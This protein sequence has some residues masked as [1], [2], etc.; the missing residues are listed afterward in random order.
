MLLVGLPGSCACRLS[1]AGSPVQDQ[2]SPPPEAWRSFGD[3][4]DTAAVCSLSDTQ[5]PTK[6]WI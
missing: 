5:P 1:S 6:G 2:P 4:V 3:S